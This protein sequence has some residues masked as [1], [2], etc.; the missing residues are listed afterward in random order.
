[1]STMNV[2]LPDELTTFLEGQVNCGQYGSSS[3]YVRDLIRRDQDRTRLRNLLL[4]G[5]TRRLQAWPTLT[6]S[7][8]CAAELNPILRNSFSLRPN[9]FHC[10]S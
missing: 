9:S 3:E 1:M 6:T 4:G 2:S 7:P 10:D 8:A 5:A